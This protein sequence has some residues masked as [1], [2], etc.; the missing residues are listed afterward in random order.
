MNKNILKIFNEFSLKQRTKTIEGRH[1]RCLWGS[2]DLVL[3]VVIIC[4]FFYSVIHSDF[5][6][7]IDYDNITCVDK[8]I[9]NDEEK[10]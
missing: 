4:F 6:I 2:I 8:D 10:S 7:R 9:R 5:S 1:L 3:R